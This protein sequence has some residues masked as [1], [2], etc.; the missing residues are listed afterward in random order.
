M[1]PALLLTRAAADN[2]RLAEKL[3]ARGVRVWQ[4]PLMQ[5]VEEPEGAVARQ[6]ILDLDRYQAIM[7]V[8]PAAARLGLQRV[9]SYWP[10]MP[11][12]IDWFA[13]GESTARCLREVGLVVHV[14]DQGQDSESLTALPAW[15]TLLHQPDLR[16]LI[17][18]GVGGREYLADQVR[19]AGGRVDYLELYRRQPAEGLRESLNEAL[20]HKPGGILLLSSQALEYWHQAA[21]EQWSAQAEWR[22]WVPSQRVAAQAAELGCRDIIICNGADDDAVIEAVMAHPLT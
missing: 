2:Q 22:C 16:V 9:D 8:S 14:P 18:R 3:A 15:Q 12:G 17:W 6:M 11:V 5:L 1:T 21:G 10:Q 13:V 4:L 7:V 19:A 20:Q